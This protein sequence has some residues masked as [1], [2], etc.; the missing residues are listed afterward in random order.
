LD[1]QKNYVERLSVDD[2][3]AKNFNILAI[4]WSVLYYSFDDP[5]KIIFRSVSIFRYFNKTILF[6]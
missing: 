5:N 3:A 1:H 2:N 4:S 6:V